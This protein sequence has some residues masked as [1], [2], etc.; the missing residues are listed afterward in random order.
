MNKIIG[1]RIKRLLHTKNGGNQSELA[2]FCGLSPQAVQKWIG[3]ETAPRGKNLIKAAEF[4]GVSPIELQFGEKQNHI[5]IAPANIG[6]RKIP[7]ISY[8]QAGTW[9]E[10]MDTY[11]P[12]DAHEWLLTDLD[13]SEHAFGLEIK[14]DSMLPEFKP[15]DRVIIDPAVNPRPGDYVVAKNGDEE[16]T[17]KKYRPRGRNDK[18][19]QVVELV[20]LNPDYESLRS[21]ITP[22]VII[23]TMVESRRYR[24][25]T[26]A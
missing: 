17:F 5:N 4:L 22:F 9:T 26:L 2:R 25:K 21:D 16:A 18:G 12:G 23:G 13:L 8:V 20:P 10:A 6:T 15:G 3:G 11:Q 24:K 1:E 14:G 7:L 19:D